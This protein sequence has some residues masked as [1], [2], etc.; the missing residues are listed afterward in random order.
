M[1]CDELELPDLMLRARQ[2]DTAA[3][4]SLRQEMVPIVSRALRAGTATTAANRWIRGTAFRLSGGE[5]G[6]AP[7]ARGHLVRE[8]A[9]CLCDEL[10]RGRQPELSPL[11]RRLE[12]VWN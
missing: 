4:A 10:M 8:V 9:R 6:P 1:H 3:L 7:A 2:G 5:P 12:T 11:R